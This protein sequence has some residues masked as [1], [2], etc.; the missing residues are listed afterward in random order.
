MEHYGWATATNARIFR[1]TWN[2][3]VC[4]APGSERL[5][6]YR[7]PIIDLQVGS[8]TIFFGQGS[9]GLKIVA[10]SYEMSMNVPSNYGL[11]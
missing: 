2:I 4:A 11:I 6:R 8:D 9:L 1:V 7:S 5:A 3:T 10:M